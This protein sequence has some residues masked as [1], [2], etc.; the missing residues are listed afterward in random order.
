MD[1]GLQPTPRHC[2][3]RARSSH[4]KGRTGGLTQKG[5]VSAGE[6]R[7]MATQ[8][9]PGPDR[10]DGLPV[11]APW[12]PVSPLTVKGC[13]E[14]PWFQTPASPRRDVIR[15]GSGGCEH[16]NTS[17][18]QTGGARQA[19]APRALRGAASLRLKAG[20]TTGAPGHRHL[21]CLNPA[22]GTR[23]PAGRG[24][25]VPTAA[26]SGNHPLICTKRVF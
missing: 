1:A 8:A 9:A 16:L 4:T 23:V 5:G 26:G 21:R 10:E 13:S 20:M 7:V 12:C 17:S 19:L 14:Y 11:A 22:Q 24:L 25:D 6:P 3:G 2:T 18:A 15:T